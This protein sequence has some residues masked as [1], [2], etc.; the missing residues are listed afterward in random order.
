MDY[1][2]KY[3]EAIEIAKTMIDDLR[4]G[5]DILSVSNLEAMF[6]ELKESE[7]EK[8]RKEIV[9]AI[10]IYCSEYHRGTKVR[11]AMLAGMEKMKEEMTAK[12]I[13]AELYSDGMLTPIIKVNDK[14]KIS[15]IKFGDKMKIIII[16]ED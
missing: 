16:K 8:I 2:K 12:A 14:E 5:E 13:D 3:K 7:D 10:N 4:K 15:D 11:N 6:P 9:S 1:E